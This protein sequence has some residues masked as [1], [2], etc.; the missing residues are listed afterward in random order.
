MLLA[1]GFVSFFTSWYCIKSPKFQFF[2]TWKLKIFHAQLSFSRWRQ[3]L[4]ICCWS[5]KRNFVSV[6][7]SKVPAIIVT[8]TSFPRS[9]CTKELFKLLWHSL[10]SGKKWNLLLWFLFCEIILFWSALVDC[11]F[12]FPVKSLILRARMLL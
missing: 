6:V 10:S 3:N 8:L 7:T 1:D 4:N 9:P 11:W 12:E 5:R 2:T